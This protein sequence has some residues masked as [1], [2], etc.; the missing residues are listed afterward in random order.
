MSNGGLIL[1]ILIFSTLVIGCHDSKNSYIVKKDGK[2]ES[3]VCD[4]G[5]GHTET[6]ILSD[7]SLQFE[8][9]A[10]DYTF[11]VDIL[12][13]AKVTLGAPPKEFITLSENAQL[14][15]IAH[16]SLCRDRNACIY[17]RKEYVEKKQQ[18]DLAFAK[19]K[20][21]AKAV[22]A[23]V[24]NAAP[25]TKPPVLRPGEDKM[26]YSAASEAR[27]FNTIAKSILYG[28]PPPPPFLPPPPPP[29]PP[30]P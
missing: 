10:R 26:T 18:Y 8:Q 29:P 28:V 17:S 24:K 15:I 4:Y 2:A 1:L 22:D 11:A 25:G 12:G 19:L 20:A 6:I 9:Y 30:P 7:C 21:V 16:A 13:K 14:L 5:Q 3:Q 23:K 27:Q